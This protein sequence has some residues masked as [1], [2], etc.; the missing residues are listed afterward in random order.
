MRSRL[1]AALAVALVCLALPASAQEVDGAE[2][3]LRLEDP[4][5]Y[6]SSGL[7][8]SRRHQAVVWTH[9]DPGASHA[10]EDG[11]TTG[12]LWVVADPG[13]PKTRTC[14]Y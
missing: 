7:A 1:A 8:L 2:V 12:W 4:R 14:S 3:A 11:H 5:I 13:L 9:N 10:A 6:E